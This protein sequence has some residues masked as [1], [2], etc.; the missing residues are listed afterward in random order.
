MGLHR[1]IQYFSVSLPAAIS[2]YVICLEERKLT[3]GKNDFW[4]DIEAPKVV[5][6]RCIVDK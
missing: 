1:F 5:I 6:V 2:N 4:L 3:K